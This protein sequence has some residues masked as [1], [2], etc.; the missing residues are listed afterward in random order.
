[1]A[2]FELLLPTAQN[3]VYT[4]NCG[5]ITVLRFESDKN[6]FYVNGTKVYEDYYANLWYKVRFEI[7]FEARQIRFKLNGIDYAVLPL[8]T[9]A[10]S[11]DNLKIENTGAAAFKG[12][13]VPRRKSL[14]TKTMFP[15]RSNRPAKKSIMS[16]SMSAPSGR[17]APYGLVG[18]S[19]RLTT[20]SRFSA[21]MT[22]DFPKRLTGRLNILRSMASIFRRSAGI[23]RIV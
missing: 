8:E 2:D 6:N 1:M 22:R 16:D 3:S 18:S 14:T 21:I 17:P 11:I 7:D 15:N 13:Y 12:G 23:R 9:A 19:A 5:E 20:S 4:L 10:N